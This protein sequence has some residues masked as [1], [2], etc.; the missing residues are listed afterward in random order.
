MKIRRFL[1]LFGA[2]MLVLSCDLS[3]NPNNTDII[4]PHYADNVTV[5]SGEITSSTTWIEGRV[6]YLDDP[7]YVSNGVTLTIQPG[8]IV[9]FSADAHLHIENG[10]T[11]VA[12]G[13]AEKPIYFTSIRDNIGGDSITNDDPTGPARGD[14]KQVWVLSGSNSNQLSY[15]HFRYGGKENVSV[16]HV[17]GKGSIDHCFVYYNLGRDDPWYDDTGAALTITD[18]SH[19]VTL[20]N[21]VFYE[22]RWPLSM[23]AN[24]NL[25]NSNSFSYDAD[26]DPATPALN[27]YFQ[28]IH[29]I[30]GEITGTTSWNETEVPY[31]LF[32]DMIYI[33]NG[34]SLSIAAAGAVKSSGP[35]AGFF[36]EGGGTFNNTSSTRFTSYRDDTV[37]DDTNHDG[38]ATQP[39]NT[40]W[41]GIWDVAADLFRTGAN[42]T[43]AANDI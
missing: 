10:A 8:T 19:G 38:S 14:W 37:M 40:D 17:D 41:Y 29:L 7:V 13:T 30:G 5:V 39:G 15:C 32:N 26:N 34:A 6:Y 20:T 18:I 23:A 27:N 16:L 22:N 43:Y 35:G 21:T 3:I 11:I 28:G 12:N 36:I 33:P 42:I 24:M 1:A 2:G 4:T 31:C 25:D 9:K